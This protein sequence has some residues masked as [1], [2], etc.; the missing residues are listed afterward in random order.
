[1]AETGFGAWIWV[2]LC[3]ILNPQ[4][5]HFITLQPGKGRLAEVSI[6]FVFDLEYFDLDGT[7]ESIF[8]HLSYSV[9]EQ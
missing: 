6:F 2:D 7:L 9:N 1:M 5:A 4:P 3:W 8:L